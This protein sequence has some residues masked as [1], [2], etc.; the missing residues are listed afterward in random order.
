MQKTFVFQ[1]K[2]WI[3]P[4]ESARWH[5]VYVDKKLTETLKKQAKKHH[6]GMIRVEV[7]VGETYWKTSLFPNKKENCY[8]LPLKKQVREIEDIFDGDS[9][10]IQI[11]LM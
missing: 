5:F 6:M 3:W 1:A 11:S 10:T 8:I 7:L 9:I 4:S 2:V